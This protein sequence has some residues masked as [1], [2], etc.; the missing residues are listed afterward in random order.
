[1]SMNNFDKELDA[2]DHQIAFFTTFGL[3]G[4]EVAKKTWK[5]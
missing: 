4:S 2:L 3:N 1:M 5:K